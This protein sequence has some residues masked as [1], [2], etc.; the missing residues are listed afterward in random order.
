MPLD[1]PASVVPDIDDANSRPAALPDTVRQD[2]AM[3][4]QFKTVT[5]TE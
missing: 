1:L 4:G 2:S 3:T 5:M